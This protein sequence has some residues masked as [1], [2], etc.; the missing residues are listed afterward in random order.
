MREAEEAS[1]GADSCCS[2]ACALCVG[3]CCCCVPAGSHGACVGVVSTVI[4]STKKDRIWPALRE[5]STPQMLRALYAA[6]SLRFGK[7]LISDPGVSLFGILPRHRCICNF[8]CRPSSMPT[9]EV[10]DFFAVRHGALQGMRMK[11]SSQGFD[12]SIPPVGFDVNEKRR[13][14]FC[15]SRPQTINQLA[16]IR[17]QSAHPTITHDCQ[18]QIEQPI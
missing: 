5:A 17:C 10:S 2:C 1:G 12:N 6:I 13:R 3:G 18:L 8:L 14:F 16:P 15:Y 7:F 9:T 4:F 11:N